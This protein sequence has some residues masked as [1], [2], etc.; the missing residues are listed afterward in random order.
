M[1]KD[2]PYYLDSLEELPTEKVSR[3]K[4]QVETYSYKKNHEERNHL[5]CNHNKDN[6]HHT[7]QKLSVDSESG[8][9]DTENEE[10]ISVTPAHF[11]SFHSLFQGTSNPVLFELQSLEGSPKST[12][13]KD[14]CPLVSTGGTNDNKEESTSFI[15]QSTPSCQPH[16]VQPNDAQSGFSESGSLNSSILEEQS[17]LYVPANSRLGSYIPYKPSKLLQHEE[18]VIS[19][20]DEN[21]ESQAST[22][23]PVNI[24]VNRTS[25]TLSLK[26]N[27]VSVT[28]KSD[29]HEKPAKERKASSV[30]SKE[31]PTE[32][33]LISSTQFSASENKKVP[34]SYKTKSWSITAV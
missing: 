18:P 13:I 30:A 7:L 31:D 17:A 32:V 27:H 5:L 26:E 20:E 9:T 34:T 8:E 29:N 11:R 3:T 22:I 19:E 14:L 24:N 23:K 12:H 6:S 25:S 2:S 16:S 33:S 10:I 21:D 15:S 4:L 28:D 1:M